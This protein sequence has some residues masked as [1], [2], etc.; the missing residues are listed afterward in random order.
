MRYD[1][2]SGD[3]VEYIPLT[4]IKY[5]AK[6]RF[7]LACNVAVRL[8]A[9]GEV[10]RETINKEPAGWA[11]YIT[12]LQDVRYAALIASCV[13][14]WSY[15]APLPQIGADGKVANWESVF[16]ADTELADLL[17]PYRV[18]LS[19]EPD[20]KGMTTGTSS[21]SSKAKAANSQTD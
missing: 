1:F 8:D 3:W 4:G 16:E 14:R 10:D 19:R 12:Q 13:T 2:E 11:G 21:R 15:D 5:K 9:E 6:S 17:E 20:P 7:G 18:K